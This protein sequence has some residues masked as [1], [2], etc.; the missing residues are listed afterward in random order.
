MAPPA[1]Y[2][3]IVSPD[4]VAPTLIMAVSVEARKVRVMWSEPVVESQAT[5]AANYV[6]PGLTVVSS[7]VET[8]SIYMLTVSPQTPSTS[9]TVTA[10]NIED[11]Y[12]NVC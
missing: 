12:G 3:W 8:S 1:S 5:I 10:S 4:I 6:I 7:E 2:S 9:Y 11:L